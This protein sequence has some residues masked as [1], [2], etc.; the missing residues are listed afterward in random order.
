M[1]GWVKVHSYTRQ[2]NEI[3]QY[4]NWLLELPQKAVRTLAAYEVSECRPQGQGIV[5]K[6]TGVET[7]ELAEQLKGAR[8]FIDQS[9]LPALPDGEYYWRELIGLQVTNQ[10][11]EELGRIESILETGAND[12]LI[13]RNESTGPDVLIPYIPSVVLEVNLEAENMIVD[14]DPSYLTE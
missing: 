12:V 5:A 9:E 1:K 2:R 10:Q 8:I 4:S 3:S 13:V 7:R 6:L 14:W 11:D